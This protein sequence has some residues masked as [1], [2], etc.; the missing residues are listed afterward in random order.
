MAA[1]ANKKCKAHHNKVD[2]NLVEQMRTQLNN[3]ITS[4]RILATKLD[5]D[6][7]VT[8]VNYF[9]LTSDAALGATA[10]TAIDEL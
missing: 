2:D 6:A 4:F 8:D 9:T 1:P 3:V 10:P 7:G 5:N